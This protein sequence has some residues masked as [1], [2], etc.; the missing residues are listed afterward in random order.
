MSAYRSLQFLVVAVAVVL[1]GCARS[2]QAVEPSYYVSGRVDSLSE[3]A[4]VTVI[5][6]GFVGSALSFRVYGNR[7]LVG[8]VGPRSYL[9]FEVEPGEF[10]LS[11]ESEN[12]ETLSLKAAPL[13]EYFVRFRL[14]PGWLFARVRMA[15][16]P[17][18]RAQQYLKKVKAPRIYIEERYEFE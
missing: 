4:I 12:L 14:R 13:E 2:Y 5:R 15:E 1:G 10:L 18:A 9:S 17:A 6:P 11:A 16:I 3:R 7:R 8:K